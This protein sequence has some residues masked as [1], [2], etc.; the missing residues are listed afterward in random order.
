[1]KGGTW[2]L[3]RFRRVEKL[4]AGFASHVYKVLDL[5]SR[6]LVVLKVYDTNSLSSVMHRSVMQE[7]SIHGRLSHPHLGKPDRPSNPGASPPH[8]LFVRLP[9][10]A[11]PA[12]CRA[13]P[14][15]FACPI[16]SAASMYAAFQDEN[17]LCL[18]LE[19]A[20][21][22][23][24]YRRLNDIK[25]TEE[26]VAKYILGPLL[27]VVSLLHRENI[28]HRDLKPENILLSSSHVLLADLGFAINT[29][30]QRPVT[31]LGTM[32]FMA[33]EICS[34]RSASDGS[35]TLRSSVPRGERPAYGPAVDVW[36]IGCIAYELLTS[37]PLFK[38]PTENDVIDS[39]VNLS[40][41]KLPEGMSLAARD[42]IA[43]CLVCEPE[44]RASAEELYSHEFIVNHMSP[45]R[46]EQLH[47]AMLGECGT[48]D[49]DTPMDGKASSLLPSV[50]EHDLQAAFPVW[51]PRSRA[52]GARQATHSQVPLMAS[53]LQK[54]STLMLRRWSASQSVN[55]SSSMGE[56][57]LSGGGKAGAGHGGGYRSENNR[58]G[59]TQVI[60]PKP[61]V[62][63][64]D[65]A[66]SRCGSKSL[67]HGA[68]DCS[69]SQTAAV[70]SVDPGQTGSPGVT[71]VPAKKGFIA[72]LFGRRKARRASGSSTAGDHRFP[73]MGAVAVDG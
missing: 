40:A 24:L 37:E 3:I 43:H 35:R 9:F 52:E 33:P 55:G 45:A 47:P 61:Q 57:P 70:L 34:V 44:W 31:Q 23:S 19:L 39:I 41:K 20:E 53:T 48:A 66:L 46:H 29:T 62:Q 16:L 67:P 7:I 22:G 59:R 32:H 38:G 51:G 21:D 69:T 36:A 73:R 5:R 11:P 49:L 26:A 13:L 6:R 58:S 27:S 64:K 2:E 18:V 63:Q 8:A 56:N 72:R 60:T 65:L 42:F 15:Q 12:D 25:R 4:D 68:E 71:V 17:C 30:L 14:E 1:M 28:V 10:S 54:S 50:R